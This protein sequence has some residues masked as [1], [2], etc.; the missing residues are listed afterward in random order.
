MAFWSDNKINL[1][2]NFLFLGEINF[3]NVDDNGLT[4]SEGG[5]NQF[6]IHSYQKPKLVTNIDD[7]GGQNA[8]NG[9]WNYQIESI[10]WDA[11]TIKVYDTFIS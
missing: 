4:F 6:L 3:Y 7:L 11:L 10:G 8:L 1:K 2:R 9:R 5:I